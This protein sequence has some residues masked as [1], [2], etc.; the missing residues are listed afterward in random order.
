MATVVVAAVSTETSCPEAVIAIDI[1]HKTQKSGPSMQHHVL[2]H[3]Y[4][5][6]VCLMLTLFSIIYLLNQ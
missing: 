3:L 1:H 4:L 2:Q 6:G 5:E